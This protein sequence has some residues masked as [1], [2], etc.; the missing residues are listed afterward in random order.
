MSMKTKIMNTI[1]AHPKLVTLGIGR[2]VT[3]GIALVTNGSSIGVTQALLHLGP[4][5]VKC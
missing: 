5:C 1:S 3:F 4:R 2:V